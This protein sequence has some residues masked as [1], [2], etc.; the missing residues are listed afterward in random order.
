MSEGGEKC[1]NPT[2]PTDAYF[3]RNIKFLTARCGHAYCET[4][5]NRMFTGKMVVPSQ[6]PLARPVDWDVFAL[7]DE[8]MRSPDGEHIFLKMFAARAGRAGTLTAKACA[9]TLHEWIPVDLLKGH[10]RFLEEML[11]LEAPFVAKGAGAVPA[12]GTSGA[13]SIA[14][15]AQRAAVGVSGA[16]GDA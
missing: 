1:A 14:E 3:D 5:V 10:V 2:C 6:R 11:N 12:H 15:M 4:C 13:G 16:A 9:E 8:H 7:I